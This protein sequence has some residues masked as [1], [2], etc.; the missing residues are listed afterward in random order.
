MKTKLEV[1]G[2]CTINISWKEGDLKCEGE[3]FED[4]QEFVLVMLFATHC[5]VQ[6]NADD[7]I[8]ATT[9]MAL[10]VNEALRILKVMKKEEGISTD[11]LMSE[12]T[13]ILTKE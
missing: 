11:A 2:D 5:T 7:G 10:I 8:G 12:V 9:A 1:P 13:K 6:H 4:V 3:G